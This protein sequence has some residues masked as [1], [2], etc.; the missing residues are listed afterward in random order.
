MARE[1]EDLEGGGDASETISA[2]QLLTEAPE[3]LIV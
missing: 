2:A 3:L 1:I